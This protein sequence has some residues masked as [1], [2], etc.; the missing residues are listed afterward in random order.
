MVEN[1]K[2]VYFNEYCESC[3]YEKLEED[4]DPCHDCLSTPMNINSHK[5]VHY[6]AKTKS[7]FRKDKQWR[8][9]RSKYLF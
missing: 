5:P 3:K 7:L 8:N 9:R 6:E 2:E 1:T 4:K